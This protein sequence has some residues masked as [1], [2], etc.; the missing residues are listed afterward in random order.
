MTLLNAEIGRGR[1]HAGLPQQLADDLDV[2]RI[3]IDEGGLRAP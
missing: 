1:R 2:M 3:L